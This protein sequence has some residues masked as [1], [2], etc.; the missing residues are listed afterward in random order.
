[1]LVL[2]QSNK[3]SAEKIWLRI[4]EKFKQATAA[5][6]KD[7]KILASHGAAEYSPDYQKSLDQLINQADHAMY[8]EKKKIKSASDIR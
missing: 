7:Y 4:K 2:P 3:K 8:E 1:M 5:N 6:K